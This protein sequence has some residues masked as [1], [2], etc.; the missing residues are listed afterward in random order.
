MVLGN[1]PCSVGCMEQRHERMSKLLRGTLSANVERNPDVA[2]W[3]AAVRREFGPFVRRKS[4]LFKHREILRTE[5]I[6]LRK[7]VLVPQSKSLLLQLVRLYRRELTN[8]PASALQQLKALFPG[9][10]TADENWMSLFMRT[11]R[12]SAA[13]LQDQVQAQFDWLDV[14]LEGC[15]KY[16]LRLLYAFALHQHSGNFPANVVTMDYGALVSGLPQLARSKFLYLCEDPEHGISVNQWR[17]IAAHKSFVIRSS[18]T[19]DVTYGRGADQVTKRLTK[20]SL[21]RAF[22]WSINALNVLR[23]ATVIVYL[24]YIEDLHGAGLKA[25]TLRLDS[26]LTHLFHNLRLVGFQGVSHSLTARFV[27]IDLFDAQS[28]PVRDA[29]IHASQVLDQLSMAVNSDPAIRP[30][31]D[32]ACVRLIHGDGS[33]AAGA[34]VRTIDAITHSEGKSTLEQYIRSIDFMIK[35]G[36]DTQQ[37]PAAYPEGRED[38]PFGSAEA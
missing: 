5:L 21:L 9:T 12:L 30:R 16:H 24:E 37:S 15:H 28:R 7:L 23:L 35:D 19:L 2:D 4:I 33:V 27:T 22:D 36:G 38:A 8:D 14:V 20:A 3:N 26:W 1:H 34:S 13:S 11:E 31:P 18:R 6:N 25:P 29:I 10:G 32:R 17:N